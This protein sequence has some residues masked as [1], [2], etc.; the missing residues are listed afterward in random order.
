MASGSLQPSVIVFDAFGTLVHIGKK[1]APYRKLIKWLAEQ[2]RAPQPNDSSMVMSSRASFIEIARQCGHEVPESLLQRLEADLA[3]EL[4]SLQLYDDT[5][6]TL[7]QL[8][9]EGFRLALCSNL[10]APYGEVILKMLPHF[11]VYAC[12]Y[13]VGATKP[14]VKI[15]QYLLDQFACQAQDIL[16][17]GDTPLA[18]VVGPTNFGMSARLINRRNEQKFSD[19]LSDMLG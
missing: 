9:S 15:Y 17:I 10:A 12:S 19:V 18:D 2:G 11:D 14:D 1:R 3:T 6:F 8:R 16:F 5:L 7:A 4:A 13:A